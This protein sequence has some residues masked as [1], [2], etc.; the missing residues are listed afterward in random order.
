MT[1]KLAFIG[2][3]NMATALINGLLADGYPADN[4]VASDQLAEKRE[5]LAGSGIHTTDDNCDAANQAE[6]VVLAVKPQ[7]LQAVCQEIKP[8]VRQTGA[9]VISI[10]AGIT[11]ASLTSWLGKETA[12]VRT[13]PNTPAMVQTGATVLHANA[14]TSQEQKDTAESILRAVGITRWLDTENQIDAATALSGSGPAYYFL[15]M[16]AMTKAA[17]DMGLPADTA[18]LLTL[19]TAL[20]AARMAMES[21]DLPAELRKKVTS[22]GGT[23]EA[24][25]SYMQNNAFE[26]LVAQAMRA[27]KKRSEEISAEPDQ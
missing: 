20:G 17:I 24:A 23:T 12:I 26:D 21:Q 1:K 13:M 4:I 3:G 2:S 22:P 15:F 11:E 6:I 8:A 16:E 27:A 5:N 14:N 7:I 10:A 25:I 18:H 9:L 19:Q